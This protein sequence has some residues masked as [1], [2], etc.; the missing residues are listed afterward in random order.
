MSS[1][2]SEPLVRLYD[3]A[4]GDEDARVCKD[5][6]DSA[7]RHLPRNYFA[8][9]GALV[10]TNAGDL[11]MNVKTV[12][13]WIMAALGAPSWMISMLV[14]IRES[15]SLLPQLAVAGVMRLYAR[16]KW[17]WVIG[18]VLQAL[19]VLAMVPVV[20][21]FDGALAGGLILGLLV[22]FSL[23]RGICSVSLK[24]VQGKT[25][26]KTR[27]GSVTGY[28]ASAAGLLSLLVGGWL[29]FGADGADESLGVYALLLVLAGVL[30]LVG[31]V[32]Y[33]LVIEPEGATE[34]G[35]SALAEAW[36]SLGL[37]R[38]DA[39]L[40]HF[41]YTRTLLLS[42]ALTAPFYVVVARD[43]TDSRVGVLGLMIIATGLASLLSSAVWG[44]FSDRSSRLVMVAAAATAAVSGFAAFGYAELAGAHSAFVFAAL[45]FL[46]GVAHS[47][48]RI[49]RKTYLVD[50]ATQQTRAAYVALSNTL[51]GI[52]LL[53]ASGV[54]L[55]SVLVGDSGIIAVLAVFSLL[56]AVV[57]WRL[58]E[59]Q[60]D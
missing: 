5:I 48:V 34:G 39:T 2:E 3:L 35:A 22:V 52:V 16:R 51:I 40:R 18:S 44:R 14:P 19:A 28:A 53:V 23:A 13:S 50:M 11:L 6:P 42:T 58:P 33:A 37:L 4:T 36:R 27:R 21:T 38:E 12:L 43:L 15:L 57:G 25:V 59:V 54:G 1:T 31:A 46:L 24:D 41:L 26:S 32:I 30:W 29:H 56:A 9:V 49:G 45:F 17:F 20:L 55:L 7:C 60:D 8:H 10:A 47:G